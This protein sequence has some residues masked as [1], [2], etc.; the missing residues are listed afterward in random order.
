MTSL[1]IQAVNLSISASYLVVA[2]LALRFLLKKAPKWVNMALWGIVALRLLLPFSIESVLSLLPSAQPVPPNIGV[3]PT[4]G[5]QSGLPVLDGVINPILQQQFAPI[6]PAAS[7][8][9]LQIWLAIAANVWGIGIA[10]LLSYTS[11]SYLRLRRRVSTAVRLEGNLYRSEHISS[12]FVLGLLRPRIYLPSQMAAAD[13]PHVIAHERAHIARRDHWWKP[14]GFVL[15]SIYWFNPLMWVAYILLCRDIELA[16][17]EKVIQTLGRE[18]RVDYSQALLSCS[19][20]RRSIAACPLAFGEVGVKKRITSI[21]NYKKPGFWIVAVALVACGALGIF[22]LTDPVTADQTIPPAEQTAPS[23]QPPV[24]STPATTQPPTTQPPA[25]EPSNQDPVILVPPAPGGTPNTEQ[26]PIWTK[27]T[28]H[29]LDQLMGLTKSQ[30]DTVLGVAGIPVGYTSYY[31]WPTPDNSALF[32]G[33]YTETGLSGSASW[34]NRNL[35]P[36]S[37][38][39]D[40][41]GAR[42][43][44][45]ALP[46]S[47]IDHVTLTGEYNHSGTVQVSVPTALALEAIAM[48]QENVREAGYVGRS[49]FTG[50]EYNQYLTIHLTDGSTMELDFYSLPGINGYWFAPSAQQQQV[51]QAKLYPALMQLLSDG[52]HQNVQARQLL[53]KETVRI[54]KDEL[55]ASAQQAVYD[56]LAKNVGSYAGYGEVSG[57]YHIKQHLKINIDQESIH[58]YSKSYS[59]YVFEDG[60]VWIDGFLFRCDQNEGWWDA[61]QE[62]RK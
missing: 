58:D 25:T 47:D 55:E 57:W 27:D 5:I 37:D 26:L 51:F 48:L 14:L 54:F 20:S 62:L 15:L 36:D 41:E 9:P 34:Y 56:W 24:T 11:F 45:L 39:G 35:Y 2:I 60:Y 7:A 59:I 8:N 16:C 22:F 31:Y 1:L 32:V 17:D 33:F 43:Q 42:Q 10:A 44:L 12:P 6:T 50:H 13:L 23:T 61:L 53:P 19:V 21:L 18:C 30:I 4:P 29:D 46:A 3:M 52:V 38:F 40:P 28:N 49:M